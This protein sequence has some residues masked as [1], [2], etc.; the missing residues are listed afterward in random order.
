MKIHVGHGDMCAEERLQKNGVSRRD[1]MKF[2]AAVSAALGL[3]ASG[4]TE[5]AAALT[6]KKRPSVVYLH[7]AE[8]TGCSEAV[9]RSVEPVMI[10]YN[11]V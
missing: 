3:G 8:C 1:F 4:A 10:S 2:C 11:F 5:V 7:F 9:L 6:Q